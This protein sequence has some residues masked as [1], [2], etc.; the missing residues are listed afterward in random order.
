MLNFFKRPSL[1]WFLSEPG[2]ALL[3]LGLSYPVNNFLSKQKSGDGHPVMVL[4]GFMSSARST[5]I[6]RNFVE[7]LGYDVYDWGL[8]RN[9]GKINYM[10][11]LLERID[12]IHQQTGKPISLIG[13][14]LGGIF[15]RQVSKERPDIIRQVITLGT[16]FAGLAEPN[17]AEWIYRMLN[18]G[19]KVK[20]VNSTFLEN[21]P[22]PAPVPTTAIYSKE[23]GIVPWQ[24]C[25]EKEEDSI[26]QNIQVRGS[27]IGLGI[28]PSVFSIIS[29]RLKLQKETWQKF[30]S[31]GI[32][33]KALLYPSL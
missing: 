10:E 14:S 32:L 3:E 19:K 27:H 16:P 12:E 23:D 2:R 22:L 15:A 26:H 13:W 1:L 30:T 33:N 24:L 28:N 7:S 9:V 25:M 8:G 11:L 4:P 17:N 29:D 18:K 6:L 31:N 21:L 5:K 20:H